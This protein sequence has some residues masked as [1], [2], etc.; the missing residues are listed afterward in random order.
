[1]RWERSDEEL[2]EKGGRK[3]YITERNG[4]SFWE[5]QRIVAFYT[6]Q[7]NEWIPEMQVHPEEEIGVWCWM[8]RWTVSCVLEHLLSTVCCRSWSKV[9]RILNLDTIQS[10]VII[11]RFDALPRIKGLRTQLMVAHFINTVMG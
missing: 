10:W 9:S 6:C 5:R 8:R 4:R 11:W 2:V 3:K 7:M 1:M